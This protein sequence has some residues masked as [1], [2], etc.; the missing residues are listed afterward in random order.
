MKKFYSMDELNSKLPESEFKKYLLLKF[1]LIIEEYGLSGISG[2]FSIILL[3]KSE[4]DY[5][6]DKYLEFSEVMLFDNMKYIHTVW[7]ASDGYSED[8]YIPYSDDAKAAIEK[9]CL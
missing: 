2:M 6:S 4:I 7:A 9:R 8:I 3:E 5:L 1:F